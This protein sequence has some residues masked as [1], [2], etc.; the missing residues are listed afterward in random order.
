M[1]THTSQL[2]SID[3]YIYYTTIKFDCFQLIFSIKSLK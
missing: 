1:V 2:T 3:V